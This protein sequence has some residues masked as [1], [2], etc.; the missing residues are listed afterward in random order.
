MSICFGWDLMLTSETHDY[1]LLDG[2]LTGLVSN[3]LFNFFEVGA[4]ISFQR[5]FPV[6][7]NITAQKTNPSSEFFEENATPPIIPSAQPN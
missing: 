7:D 3:R 2:T 4:G 1:P 5:L 6:D